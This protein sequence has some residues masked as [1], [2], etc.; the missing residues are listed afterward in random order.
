MF[1]VIID[2]PELI[3]SILEN[4]LLI[5]LLIFLVLFFAFPFLRSKYKWKECC[6]IISS[7][8]ISDYSKFEKIQI[9]S[10]SHSR[11]KTMWSFDINGNVLISDHNIVLLPP[12]WSFILF[13]TELPVILSDKNKVEI[14]SKTNN[15][16]IKHDSYT[17]H[18]GK[19]IVNYN[20]HIK[21]IEQKKEIDKAINNWLI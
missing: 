1:T 11:W 17:L 15:I 12:K 10:D 20:L 9:G 3:R 19:A 21:N 4:L 13:H 6:R 14:I 7:L 8:N 2:M 5:F 16:L 18:L